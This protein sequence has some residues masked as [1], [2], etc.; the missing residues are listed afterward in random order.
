MAQ[1]ILSDSEIKEYNQL[2]Y[3]TKHWIG[4]KNSNDI[5]ML[6]RKLRLNAPQCNK[7]RNCKTCANFRA[8]Y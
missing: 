3:N 5:L 4:C 1:H 7:T 6:D 2:H 8:C